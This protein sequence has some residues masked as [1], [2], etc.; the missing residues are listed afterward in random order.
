[1]DSL[2]SPVIARFFM[3]DLEDLALRRAVYR[4]VCCFFCVDNRF[5][6][7]LHGLEKLSDTVIHLN[8]IHPNIQF[9]LET[10]SDDHI[11]FLDIDIYRRPDGCLGHTVYRKPSYASPYLNA[12]SYHH[13]VNKHSVPDR[14]LH[15]QR[16]SSLTLPFVVPTFNCISRVLSKKGTLPHHYMVL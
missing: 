1:M 5:L 7:W 15:L 14:M 16:M 10:G 8:Q 6:F 2:L 3:E 9:T 4:P 11:P 13:P 12:M